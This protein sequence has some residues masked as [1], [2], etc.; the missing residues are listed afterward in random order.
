VLTH[1]APGEVVA[2]HPAHPAGGKSAVRT[3]FFS[4]HIFHE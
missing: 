2:A 3:G 4:I 1:Q